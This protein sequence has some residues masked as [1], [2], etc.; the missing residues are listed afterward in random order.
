MGLSYL[1]M[2]IDCRGIKNT[3]VLTVELGKNASKISLFCRDRMLQRLT[4]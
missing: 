4:Y 2:N 1:K 3:L